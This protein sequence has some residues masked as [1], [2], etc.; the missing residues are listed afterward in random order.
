[1]PKNVS[2]AGKE[3]TDAPDGFNAALVTPPGLRRC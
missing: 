2:G 1:M 3:I